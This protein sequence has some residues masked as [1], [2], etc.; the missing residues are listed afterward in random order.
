[1]NGEKHG[2]LAITSSLASLGITLAD[3]K[4]TVA[5]AAAVVAL[6]GSVI[7][8]VRFGVATWRYIRRGACHVEKYGDRREA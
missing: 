5:V 4:E 7:W 2:I 8:T 3:V 6:V 1:M